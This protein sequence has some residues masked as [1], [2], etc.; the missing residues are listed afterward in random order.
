VKRLW[1]RTGLRHEQPQTW[2]EPRPGK[3]HLHIVRPGGEL[4]I[5][6]AWLAQ[7]AVVNGNNLFAVDPDATLP[8]PVELEPVIAGLQR[9]QFP[10]KK[11]GVLTRLA[12][13]TS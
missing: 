6:D 3:E 8:A 2:S 4:G 13:D 1:A 12:N 10:R 7:F 9:V 5:A 11:E